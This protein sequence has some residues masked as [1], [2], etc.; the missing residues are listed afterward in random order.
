MKIVEPLELVFVVNLIGV[1]VCDEARPIVK[2]KLVVVLLTIV[3]I[4][5]LNGFSIVA[6]SAHKASVEIARMSECPALCLFG[7]FG[8][9]EMA[10]TFDRRP[11]EF[12]WGI[13]VYKSIALIDPVSDDICR[14]LAL[15]RQSGVDLN[16]VS[17]V[18]G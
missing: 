15:P 14:G 16:V 9:V 3:C 6:D 12:E 5:A 17:T 8:L 13:E 11:D 1:E 4:L 2:E 18:S 7:T 10:K